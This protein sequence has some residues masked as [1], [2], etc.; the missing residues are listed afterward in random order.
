MGEASLLHPDVSRMVSKINDGPDL[1]LHLKDSS[2][3]YEKAA[4][5]PNM[6]WLT[7]KY[8]SLERIKCYYQENTIPTQKEDG[9]QTPKSNRPKIN[10]IFFLG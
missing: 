5:L 1:L 6:R 7:S 9:S 4:G 10:K 8:L 3:G 2:E